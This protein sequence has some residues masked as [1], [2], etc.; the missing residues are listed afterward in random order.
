MVTTAL[1]NSA[2]LQRAI[3]CSQSKKKLELNVRVHSIGQ[4]D[5]E[6]FLLGLKGT[7]AFWE[8]KQM[9]NSA[10]HQTDQLTEE[11]AAAD[12]QRATLVPTSTLGG[13][14]GEM[15]APTSINACVFQVYQEGFPSWLHHSSALP[16]L[17]HEIHLIYST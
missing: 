2:L 9:T 15:S 6:I 5:R 17:L 7:C 16:F 8:L 3:E 11:A 4:L 10:A 1:R 13:A 14:D 12:E